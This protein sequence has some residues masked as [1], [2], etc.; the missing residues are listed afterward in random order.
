MQEEGVFS[1][2]IVIKSKNNQFKIH[3]PYHAQVL[4]GE[5]KVN[6]SS[7]HFHLMS[8]EYSE[9]TRSINVTNEFNV[10]V[11]VHRVSIPEEANKFVSIKGFSPVILKPGESRALTEISLKKEAWKTRTLDSVLTLHTNV[12][13]MEV[14]LLVF[15]GKV[16]SVRKCQG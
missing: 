10:P 3:L 8:E 12:S 1:G 13:S 15:H 5:L 7:T 14:P 6:E 2:K 4:K 9:V 11:V 16:T